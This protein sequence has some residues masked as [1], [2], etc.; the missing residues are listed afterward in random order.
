MELIGT[1]RK[2]AKALRSIVTDSETNLVRDHLLSL[3]DRCEKLADEA[4]REIAESRP[5]RGSD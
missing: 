3:I 5:K 4:E 1:L 2:Q